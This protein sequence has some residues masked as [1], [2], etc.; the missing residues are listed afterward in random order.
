M[1]EAG[2]VGVKE[3]GLEERG[4]GWAGAEEAGWVGVKEVGL[5]GGT[6]G[7]LEVKE[8]GRVVDMEVEG[9]EGEMEKGVGGRG[10]M[11]VEVGWGRCCQEVCQWS[12]AV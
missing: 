4:V 6:E 8:G 3:E 5:E 2:P 10:G 1:A 11:G 9:R 7:G 12:Q